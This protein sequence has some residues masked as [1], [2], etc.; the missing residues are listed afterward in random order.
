MVFSAE[1]Q[2]L[3]RFVPFAPGNHPA[4]LRGLR[5]ERVHVGL[6]QIILSAAGKGEAYPD[7]GLRP[8]LAQDGGPVGGKFAAAHPVGEGH[9]EG[10]GKKAGR[11]GHELAETL[12]NQAADGM[13]QGVAAGDMPAF[14]GQHRGDQVLRKGIQQP[15]GDYDERIGIA[16]GVGVGYHV[17]FKV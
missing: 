9:L 6:G 3:Q 1:E 11:A 15:G 13:V 17:H 7:H 12:H 5:D 8:A 16:V 4:I 14:V 2:E 10:H